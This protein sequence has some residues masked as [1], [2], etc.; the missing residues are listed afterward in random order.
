MGRGYCPGEVVVGPSA[1]EV[2]GTQPGVGPGPGTKRTLIDGDRSRSGSVLDVVPPE[3]SHS[4]TSYLSP[5]P[6]PPSLSGGRGWKERWEGSKDGPDL[7]SL[8]SA[9]RDLFREDLPY[10]STEKLADGS[11]G[12][13][14]RKTPLYKHLGPLVTLTPKDLHSGKGFRSGVSEDMGVGPSNR[15]RVGGLENPRLP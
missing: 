1:E 4:S 14:R 13:Y 11:D 9:A 10:P 3:V 8:T 5:T 7:K 2:S 12:G 6:R 15:D